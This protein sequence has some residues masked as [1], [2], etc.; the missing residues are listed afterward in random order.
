MS[1]SCD[2]CH[3]SL[4]QGTEILQ[5]LS[6]DRSSSHSGILCYFSMEKAVLAARCSSVCIQFIH[7]SRENSFVYL[8]N[9]FDKALWITVLCQS[10]SVFQNLWLFKSQTGFSTKQIFSQVTKMD[11]NW[12]LQEQLPF[13]SF[14]RWSLE[15]PQSPAVW[16]AET[17]EE[18]MDLW[19]KAGVRHHTKQVQGV[20]INFFFYIHSQAN[21]R[22]HSEHKYL[23]KLP[24]VCMEIFSHPLPAL[25]HL[26]QI[27]Q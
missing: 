1:S 12:L 6:P 2:K 16:N 25:F 27:S 14:Y 20:I 21:H 17:K 26:L 4:A 23:W 5:H 24:S 13:L 19:S 11:E 18:A 7:K 3:L 8:F 9:L 10:M 15:G 22:A